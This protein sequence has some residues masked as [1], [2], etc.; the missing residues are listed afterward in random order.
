MIRSLISLY[1]RQFFKN[2]YS[3]RPASLIKQKDE[4][5]KINE[6]TLQ[7]ENSHSVVN[8]E[9]ETADVLMSSLKYHLHV[10]TEIYK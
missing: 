2:C 10:D 1:N 8:Q 4:D 3:K 9:R 5:T 7:G 6:Y